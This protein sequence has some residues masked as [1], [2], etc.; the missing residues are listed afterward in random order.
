M[1]IKDKRIETRIK[2]ITWGTVFEKDGKVYIKTEYLYA[3][4][5]EEESVT[6]AV[7]LNNGI[8][9]CFGDEEKVHVLNEAILTY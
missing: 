8:A 2:D 9:E 1:I 6:N 7:D 4:L 3:E 5:E